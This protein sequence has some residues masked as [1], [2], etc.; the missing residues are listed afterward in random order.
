MRLYSFIN[1]SKT[2]KIYKKLYQCTTKH[3][4]FI[5]FTDGKLRSEILRF[6][7]RNSLVTVTDGK[8]LY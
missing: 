2:Q 8:L 5:L 4:Q 6:F 7:N 3:G 1:K